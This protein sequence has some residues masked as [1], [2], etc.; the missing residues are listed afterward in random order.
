MELL[1][2]E[3]GISGYTLLAQIIN[4]LLLLFI[5]KKFLYKPLMGFMDQRS[6][7][8]NDG[9]INAEKAKDELSR[10]NE[11]REEKIIEGEREAEKIIEGSKKIALEK[12]AGILKEADEKSEIIIQEA[13]EIAGEERKAAAF[14]LKKDLANLVALASFNFVQNN[15]TSEDNEKIIN[16]YLESL[17]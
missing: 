7:V 8:I 13:K 12:G 1:F 17:N 5:L 15:I 16:K 9:L 4:F 14:G 6:A 2:H 10:V 11:I 3:L